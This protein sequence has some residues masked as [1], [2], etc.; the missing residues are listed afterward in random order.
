MPELPPGLH[1]AY[2]P[3]DL[4][5][6]LGEAEV[7]ALLR[8]GHLVRY[9]RGV[10]LDR[11]RQLELRTR[12]AA[13]LLLA[14]PEGVLTSH[15]AARL[16]GCT[17]ADEGTAHV[18]ADYGRQLHNRPGLRFHQGTVEEQN[19][20]EVDGLRL[21]ALDVVMAG[22]LCRAERRIALAIIDQA[23]ATGTPARREEFKEEVA[24]Q[25]AE[26]SDPR[27]TRRAVYLLGLATGLPESPAES[28]LLV[29]LVDAG[30]PVP[31]LQVAVR[32]LDGHERYRLDFAWEEPKI[33][34]EYDGYEAHTGRSELDAARDR[35]LASRGW[36][37]IRAGASD[38]RHPAQ[39][40]AEV[41][42]AF[43]RRRF[44]A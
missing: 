31:A 10:L 14:G 15:T 29:S 16:Y 33:A 39:V 23:L 12:A 20:M 35:D 42:T 26:R 17:A 11:T 32:D 28:Q 18:L 25:V 7:R 4:V 38:L 30:L 43:R 1:G 36:L 2:R 6:E 3:A 13:G 22:L 37:V 9:S 44:A 27:G 21:E 8:N 41:R 19:V 24:W 5:R 34:V 40:V